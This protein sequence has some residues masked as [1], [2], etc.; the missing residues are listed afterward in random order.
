MRYS[1]GSKYVL[2]TGGTSGIGRA[3]V[4]DLLQEG[5]TVVTFSRSGSLHVEDLLVTYARRFFVFRADI[6]TMPVAAILAEALKYVP[7]IDILINNVGGGG[8]WGT[9]EF[10]TT[11][12]ATMEEVFNKN[13]S[14]TVELT[15]AVLPSMIQR[16]WGRV[17]V[18]SSIYGKEA[19]GRPAFT[20]AKAAQIAL[21]KSLSQSPL[22]GRA[23]ITCNSIAP[24]VIRAG[25]WAGDEPSV[26]EISKTIPRGVIGDPY[27]V[28]HLVTFLCS[29]F[30]R[31]ITGACIPVD[32]GQS[33]SF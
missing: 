9:S 24:G 6:S 22:I 28:A 12:L 15:H 5:C 27:D 33:S 29:S 1:L 10:T 20:V 13:F 19:G 21:M 2:V 30:A 7:H 8:R 14:A 3:I 11:P 18:I 16:E 4:H 23:N 26:V 25:A 17:L 32:G 31:H